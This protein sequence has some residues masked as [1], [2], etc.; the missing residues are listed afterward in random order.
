[1]IAPAASAQLT[2]SDI[3]LAPE[4]HAGNNE[5]VLSGGGLRR[6]FFLGIYVAGLYVNNAPSDAEIIVAA[7]EVMAIQLHIVSDIITS[8]LMISPLEDDFEKSTQ[9]NQANFFAAGIS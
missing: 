1:L 2:I 5:L 3:V 8:N 4:Y 6:K 9:G 7:N